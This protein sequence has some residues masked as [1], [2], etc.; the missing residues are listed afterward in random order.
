M[1]AFMSAALLVV[2]AAWPLCKNGQDVVAGS[3]VGTTQSHNHIDTDT[4]PDR[5]TIL[6]HSDSP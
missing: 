2:G 4:A 5:K 3:I 1:H 6:N